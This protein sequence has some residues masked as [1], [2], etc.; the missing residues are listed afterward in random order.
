LKQGYKGIW[1]H[2]NADFLNAYEEN[3]DYITNPKFSNIFDFNEQIHSVYGTYK[4][5]AGA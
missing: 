3:G 2:V 4:T 1:R 5:T